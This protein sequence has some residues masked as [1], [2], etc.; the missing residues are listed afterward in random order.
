[1]N[2]CRFWMESDRWKALESILLILNVKAG[3]LASI[4]A[5]RWRSLACC[6]IFFSF[7]CFSRD[8]QHSFFQR[9]NVSSG[10]EIQSLKF[11]LWIQRF[12][13]Q[14][15]SIRRS[16][17]AIDQGRSVKAITPD[18]ELHRVKSA[19]ISQ[20]R[21]KLLTIERRSPCENG[22]WSRECL[23]ESYSDAICREA[24][25]K[26]DFE[27]ENLSGKAAIFGSDSSAC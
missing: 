17:N 5:L 13:Y 23:L 15:L 19:T 9:F 24:I 14:I 1:M 22:I 10:F 6:S 2:L 20:W 12:E 3:R 11:Q 16:S 8:L 4:W 25:R 21:S 18:C 7:I 27:K 26:I